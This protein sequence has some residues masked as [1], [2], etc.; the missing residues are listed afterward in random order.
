MATK[1]VCDV[2]GTADDVQ[3]CK[4]V[5]TGPGGVVLRTVDVEL[6]LRGRKRAAKFMERAVNLHPA[7]DKGGE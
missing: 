1:T 6:G 3:E 2:Y 4:L 5:L 7:T